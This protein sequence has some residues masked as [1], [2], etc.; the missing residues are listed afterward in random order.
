MGAVNYRDW[1]RGETIVEGGR[2][3]TGNITMGCGHGDA[4]TTDHGAVREHYDNS[5]SLFARVAAGEDADGVWVAGAL[6]PGVTAEQIERAMGLQLSGHW[7]PSLTPGYRYDLLAAL[8]VPVPGFAM[9]RRA[10]SVTMRDGAMAASAVPVRFEEDCGCGG[11]VISAAE[12]D[13]LARIERRLARLEAAERPALI[14]SM[15]ARL[16]HDNA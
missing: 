13:Y 16:G 11:N 4:V 6:Y 12:A 9:A 5:C 10:P 2:V 1:M 3:V 8:L 7:L 14:A 15:R